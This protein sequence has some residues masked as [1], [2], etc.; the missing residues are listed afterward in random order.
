M[1]HWACKQVKGWIEHDIFF[2]YSCMFLVA[3]PI[4]FS[5]LIS[6]ASSAEDSPSIHTSQDKVLVPICQVLDEDYFIFQWEHD[7]SPR[8]LPKLIP[9]AFASV[10]SHYKASKGPRHIKS[11]LQGTKWHSF[12]CLIVSH[13]V[14]SNKKKLPQHLFWCLYDVVWWVNHIHVQ[15]ETSVGEKPQ[16]S[17]SR[18]LLFPG[19]SKVDLFVTWLFALVRQGQPSPSK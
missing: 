10:S 5:F 2:S 6:Q 15:R 19:E 17:D 11:C 13:I 3:F 14:R 1:F 4:S 16:C 7:I 18:L 12:L 8:C 9:I